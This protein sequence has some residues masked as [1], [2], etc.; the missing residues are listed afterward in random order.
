MSKNHK[1]LILL[2]AA[3]LCA[4]GAGYMIYRYLTP[5]RTIIYAFNSA[6]KAGT[7][8]TG[9]MLAPMEVDASM[10][11]NGSPYGVNSYFVTNDNVVD[12]IMSGDVLRADVEQGTP[13][14]ESLLSLN[15]GSSIIQTMKSDAVAV[16]IPMNSIRGVTNELSSG[17]RVNIYANYSGNG[18]ITALLMQDMRVLAVAKGSDGEMSA[19]TIE[20]TPEQSIELVNAQVYT[21]LY[22]GLVNQTGYQMIEDPKDCIYSLG[23]LSEEEETEEE[24]EDGT[25][26]GNEENEENWEDTEYTGEDEIITVE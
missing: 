17:S 3:L 8:I 16:S 21:S 4:A 2:V 25:Q 23:G 9:A 11:Y 1:I 20:C 10:V 15:S 14:M 24:T 7:Q 5:Q 22:L 6:Y 19:V 26:E 12:V 18:S 13:L